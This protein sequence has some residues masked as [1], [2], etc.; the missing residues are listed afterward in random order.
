MKRFLF[1]CQ[2]LFVVIIA[3]ATAQEGDIIF[4]EGTRWELLGCP[5][6]ADSAL[7]H[8]LETVLPKDRPII[9]SNWDGFTAYWSIQQDQLYLDSIYIVSGERIPSDTALGTRYYF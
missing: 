6:G 5:V 3:H 4:I 8:K 2:L 9:T 7:Y 1:L